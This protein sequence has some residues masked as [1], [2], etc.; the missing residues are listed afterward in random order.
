M[1]KQGECFGEMALLD[2][3]D[4]STTAVEP[5]QTLALYRQDFME[6]LT[7]HPQVVERTT[8]L[9]TQR[10]RTINHMLGDLAFLDVPS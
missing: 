9:L 7:Q 6:F 3:S 2:G 5:S 4:R 10:L 1:L 8:C